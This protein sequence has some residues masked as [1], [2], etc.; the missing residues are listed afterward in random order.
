MSFVANTGSTQ[1][2]DSA[3]QKKQASE[4]PKLPMHFTP[5]TMFQPLQQPVYTCFTVKTI[6]ITLNK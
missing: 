3:K 4:D 5:V 2:Q 6:V 1:F